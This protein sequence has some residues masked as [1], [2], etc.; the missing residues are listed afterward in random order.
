MNYA[1]T[2]R[3]LSSTIPTLSI[4]KLTYV[5]QIPRH[6]NSL[7]MIPTSKEEIKSIIENLPNKTSSGLDNL[8]NLILKS[9][10]HEI[11]M[12]LEKNI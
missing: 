9:L 1:T 5:K 3:E 4:D 12:P 7:F 8:N 11:V 2:I 10:K 6:R